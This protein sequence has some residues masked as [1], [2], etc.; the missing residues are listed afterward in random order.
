MARTVLV[1]CLLAV[2]SAQQAGEIKEESHRPIT[3]EVCTKSGGCVGKSRL[4]T[5]DAQWRWLH[6]ARKN[7]YKNCISG[8]PP[9]WDDEIC[10]SGSACASGCAIEGINDDDYEHT[11]GIKTVPGGVDLKF[12][13]GESI[14]SRLYMLRD[15]S[16]YEMFQLLNKEFTLEVDVS[17]LQCGINGAVYFVEMDEDG[18][19]SK[20]DNTAGAKYGTGYCDA[21]CPHDLKF[22]QGEA[23]YKDWHETDFGPEGHYG[24]CCAELDIW[25]ANKEATAFTTHACDIVGPLRCEGTGAN[26]CGDT[27]ADCKCCGEQDCSCCGRYKGVCDKD[28][29]DYNHFRL[30]EEDYYGDGPGFT[31]DTSKPITVV[32]QFLTTDGTDS[33]DL[34]EM[35]R[36]YVQ[37]GKVIQNS[38][39]KNLDGYDGDSIN[40]EM[41]DAQKKTFDNTDDFTPKG[42]MA[43]MGE[44]MKR[45]M[46]L[47]LSLWDDMKTQMEW[48]DSASPTDQPER[49]PLTKPGVRRGP[50]KKG[51]GDP[52]KLRTKYPNAHV[53]YRNIR[54]GEIDSTYTKKAEEDAE[55][56]DEG[57]GGGLDGEGGGGDHRREGGGGEEEEHGGGGW[58][59]ALDEAFEPECCTASLEANDPCRTCWAGAALNTGWCAKESHCSRDCGGTWCENGATKVFELPPEPIPLPLAGRLPSANVLASGTAAL[60]LSALAGVAWRSS[61]RRPAATASAA[62]Q[63]PASYERLQPPATAP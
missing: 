41:C 43:G 57:E 19:M 46:V 44:A 24:S 42:K 12:K 9:S 27:P 53:T 59:D 60:L 21:Q 18:G 32:T 6:D 34:K 7:H 54:I 31:V 29:C 2:A 38:K 47:V 1:S 10:S 15:E 25:E 22:I 50:C 39:V 14:G 26:K 20:G 11:Y 52:H 58:E 8:T 37:D 61:R 17:T 55:K 63:G 30:G 16:H 51:D 40:N 33:G 48:L 3:L 23:N 36:L 5:M 45:G 35:R 49:F 13:N 28:G 56:I 4:L 62:G